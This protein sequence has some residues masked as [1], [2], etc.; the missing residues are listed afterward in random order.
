MQ[1]GAVLPADYPWQGGIV[2]EAEVEVEVE[3]VPGD[4]QPQSQQSGPLNNEAGKA[5]NRAS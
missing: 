4:G 2:H 1:P 5:T 3:V